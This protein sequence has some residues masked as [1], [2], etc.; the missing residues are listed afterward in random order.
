MR[1]V[2]VVLARIRARRLLVVLRTRA[3]PSNRELLD[4]VIDF[5]MV[6][7]RCR[8]TKRS[9][10]TKATTSL[11]WFEVKVAEGIQW[12]LVVQGL[13]HPPLHA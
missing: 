4:V 5:F 1:I 12:F 11:G 6:K 2:L 13:Y 3:P 8:A 7:P 9:S 10:V